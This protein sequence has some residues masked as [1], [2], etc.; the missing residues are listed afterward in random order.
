MRYVVR[1]KT[2]ESTRKA[3]GAPAGMRADLAR[4]EAFDTLFETFHE[5]VYAYLLARTGQ[6]ESARDLLQDVFLRAWRASDAWS[7]QSL[8]ARRYWLFAVAKHACVCQS[9]S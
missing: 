9:K 7:G 2:G 1:A 3:K 4:D 5:Q 6:K 8:S